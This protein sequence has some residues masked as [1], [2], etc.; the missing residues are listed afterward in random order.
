VRSFLGFTNFYRRFIREFSEIVRPLS[1]LT[2]K[3][4]VFS[5]TDRAETAFQKL[6]KI[7]IS[8]LILV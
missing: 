8:A 7:F 5:W 6:K 4:Q 1:D 3:D 2:H